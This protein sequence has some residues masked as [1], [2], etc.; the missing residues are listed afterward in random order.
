[1]LIKLPKE[2]KVNVRLVFTVGPLPTSCKLY[3]KTLKLP[4]VVAKAIFA[5]TELFTDSRAHESHN[6]YRGTAGAPSVCALRT[7]LPPD[8]GAHLE[9]QV[10]YMS[11]SSHSPAQLQ[12]SGWVLWV[13]I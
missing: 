6:V 8:P 13:I 7:Q 12:S 11:L 1:M 10:T 5:I 9:M 3:L 4:F 2:R